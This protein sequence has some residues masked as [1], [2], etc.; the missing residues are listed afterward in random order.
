[1][2]DGIGWLLEPY[3]VDCVTFARGIP[4]TALAARLGS[5]PGE[6]ARPGSAQ[7][8]QEALG[9][10]ARCV[11]RVGEAAG[12]AFAV[13]YGDAV[14]ATAGGLAAVSRGGV[15]AV[16]FLLTPWSP[17]SLFRHYLDGACVTGFGVG[18]EARRYGA[19]PG[20][21][22]P[23]LEALGVLPSGPQLDQRGMRLTMLAIED[24]FGLRL[25]R[26]QVLDEKL[27]MYHL[28]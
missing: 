27:P 23:A 3:L 8:A 26:P 18:E 21:L 22:V 24:H 10:G 12:W 16:N 14:G 19:E 1:M 11:A 13:E 9:S 5:G 20:L 4:P 15:A 17:P 28:R 2:S 6:D 7:D 25:P